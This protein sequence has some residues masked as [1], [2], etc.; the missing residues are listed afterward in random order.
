MSYTDENGNKCRCS[1]NRMCGL[2]AQ[3]A[4]KMAKVAAPV[5]EARKLETGL[6]ALRAKYSGRT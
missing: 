6:E 5:I 1:R 2:H 4:K 3:A